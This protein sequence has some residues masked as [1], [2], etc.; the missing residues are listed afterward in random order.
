M[1]ES[2]KKLWRSQRFRIWAL[3]FLIFLLAFILRVIYPVSRPLV[4]SDRAFHFMNA[5][6]EQNWIGTY[7]RY[8]P[9]VSIMWLAGIP[10]RLF[11]VANGGLTADQML[12][13]A[14]TQPG[15]LVNALQV[16]V[17]PVVFV[18]SLCIALT[19]PLLRRLAGH[20]IALA[21]ALFLALDPFYIGYSK[22]VHPDALL[23][24]F[25][26]MSALFLLTYLKERRLLTLA[27]SG[28]FAGFSFLSKSPSIFLIPYA[29]L[30][31][32][33]GLLVP[34]YRYRART[35]DPTLPWAKILWPIVRTL[36]LWAG[37]AALA[38][39]IFWPAMWVSPL[40]TIQNVLGGVSK[41]QANPHDNP[42]FFNNQILTTDPGI[43]YYLSVIGWKTT[44]IT[45]PLVVVAT[46]FALVRFRSPKSWPVWALLA[47]VFF[48][49]IQMTLGQFKQIAYLLPVFPAL[50]VIAAFGLVWS[51]EALA[52]LKPLRAFAHFDR[53]FI[54]L[55]I[56]VQAII[57]FVSYPYFTA[58]Y[59]RLLGGTQVAQ[60][61]LP[62]QDQGEGLEVAARFLN[63]LPHGQ[64]ETAQI[65][66]RGA[67][68][69][70][71]EFEGRTLVEISPLARYRIYSLNH[72]MRQL[73]DEEW[74][75]QWEA[76]QK[77]EPLLIVEVGGIP[78]VW[79]YGKLPEDLAAGG[80]AFDLDYRLGENITLENVRLKSDTISSGDTLTLLMY[81]RAE[82][83][84]SGDYTVFTHLLSADDELVAQQ[85]NVPLLGIRPTTTW[86]KGELLEDPYLIL[87][88]SNLPGGTYLLT[89][90]MYDTLSLKRLPVYDANGELI[91]DARV[92]VGTV[93]VVDE[94]TSG[95]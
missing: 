26:L 12:G 75:E 33:A 53:V 38:Y 76:D 69:F 88:D 91:P 22:V 56:G 89:V 78:Q 18:I 10:L 1:S 65:H 74:L 67:I 45:L 21:G 68:V 19:Y 54:I 64:D 92:V 49:T 94:T 5:V 77:N 72:L 39:V 4:W 36:L 29:S 40:E 66:P 62:Q 52:R 32:T 6:G 47:Y 71:R 95:N 59:N 14:P 60:Y 24:T 73:G 83:E 9:G 3:V 87:T 16:A 86:R 41:H 70:K 13:V 50:D 82:S 84:I 35:N 61:I 30:V 44:A 34:W 85:D 55:I 81:W 79:V 2:V 27:L 23:A 17:L 93:E 90:G 43:G 15:T 46:A 11:S 25:M 51:A 20:R 63:S 8:H 57:T 37:V 7:K 80:P 48:F 42:V 28:L 58:H 31:V